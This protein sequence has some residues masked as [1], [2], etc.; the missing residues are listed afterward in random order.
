MLDGDCV[1]IWVLE[2]IVVG[3]LAE[4]WTSNEVWTAVENTVEETV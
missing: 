4:V 2:E 3:V 1:V